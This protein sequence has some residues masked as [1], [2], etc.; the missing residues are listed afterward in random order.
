MKQRK[1]P[2]EQRLL[3]IEH[4]RGYAAQRNAAEPEHEIDAPKNLRQDDAYARHGSQQRAL[5]PH[6]R[7]NEEQ[8]RVAEVEKFVG[9]WLIQ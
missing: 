6:R 4:V 3:R 8:R 1:A 7:E 9:P 2:R 5:G